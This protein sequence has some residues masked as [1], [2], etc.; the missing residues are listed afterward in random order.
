MGDHR[1][2]LGM[3]LPELRLPFYE[4]LAA[5][6]QMGVEYVW[7][8]G[9]PG[10]TSTAKVS[11]FEIDRM[12]GDV[13]DYDLELFLIQVG[14]PFKKI[15]L[16]DLSLDS[17][18]DD[19][20][21]QTDLAD[22]ERAMHI[23]A[24]TGVGA[25][26]AFT[27]AW[28]GEYRAGRP[29]W[30]MRWLTR[31][32]VISDGEFDKLTKA[33]ELALE[34]AEKLEVDLVMA[35]MPWNYTNT[36]ANFLRLVERLGSPRLKVMW[37]PADNFNAG[38]SDVATAGFANVRPFLHSLHLKDLHVNE[39]QACDFEYRPIGRGDI[40]YPTV[41]HRLR[42][43]Q[44]DA[45]LAVATHFRPPSGS[46]RDAMQ[47][48]VANLKALIADIQSAAETGDADQAR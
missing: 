35:M 22:L 9:V 17:L 30:P 38:E 3:Y 40:D 45:V 47:T 15:D 5:A 29:T 10:A 23:A 16:I 34:R 8:D 39:G 32:G 36:T 24:R 6:H 33:F 31:G 21:F 19:P 28:P 12:A 7:F 25:A 18:Q 43:H 13:A 44:V 14:S 27:F 1:F 11:D 20:V 46:P 48:N 4:A 41:L 2:K 26:Y 37:G 42:E